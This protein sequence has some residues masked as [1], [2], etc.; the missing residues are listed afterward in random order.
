MKKMC[1]VFML[2]TCTIAIQGSRQE[3]NI[4]TKKTLLLCLEDI[5]NNS[6]SG[7]IESI[8][9]PYLKKLTVHHP[10]LPQSKWN[11]NTLINYT[12]GNFFRD[13]TKETNTSIFHNEALTIYCTDDQKITPNDISKTLNNQKN[14][15]PHLHAIILS[16]VHCIQGG[17]II[18]NPST[19]RS[20]EI[21]NDR[22]EITKIE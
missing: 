10:D 17:R 14:M 9:A 12:E 22:G 1:T 5:A 13:A 19:K 6:T 11:L 4:P 8:N 20:I 16:I 21:W 2:F 3:S 18:S 15:P 7:K